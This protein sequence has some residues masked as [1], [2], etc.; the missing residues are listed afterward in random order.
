[1]TVAHIGS[2][3]GCGGDRG[4]NL[5]CDACWDRIPTRLPGH[6]RAWRRRLGRMRTSRDWQ[7][8]ERLHGELVAWLRAN[9]S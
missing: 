1:M 2:C 9:R 3:P 5:A 4:G 8:V 7:G 6:E